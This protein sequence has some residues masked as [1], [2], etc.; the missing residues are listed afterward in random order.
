MADDIK[1]EDF[2]SFSQEMQLEKI[3]FGGV[4]KNLDFKISKKDFNNINF[5]DPIFKDNEHILT[6]S[7]RKIISIVSI[8]EKSNKYI[9]DKESFNEL[10][11]KP[12]IFIKAFD[13]GHCLLLDEINL[14]NPSIFQC[15]GEA[16][17]T[18][19][20]SIDIPGLPLKEYKMHRNFCLVA[21]QNP[22]KGKF[23][24]KRKELKSQFLSKFQIIYFD[25]FKENELVEICKGLTKEKFNKLTKEEF[26]KYNNIISKLIKFHIKLNNSPEIKSNIINCTIREISIF[27]QALKDKNNKLTQYQLILIIYGSNIIY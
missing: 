2:L 10:I 12:G 22:N 16:L 5:E 11:F 1:E 18:K 25:E 3:N 6:R 26:N 13:E 9:G 23:D 27:I 8:Y 21:T 7:K 14:A 15:I 17:D 20:L 4:I 19:T 24:K